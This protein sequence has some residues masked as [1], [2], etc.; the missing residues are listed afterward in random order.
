MFLTTEKK[1]FR[2]ILGNYHSIRNTTRHNTSIKLKH[3][4]KSERENEYGD[5]RLL[6]PVTI[7]WSK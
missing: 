1:R 5:P 7:P 4:N 2:H 3:P 6:N